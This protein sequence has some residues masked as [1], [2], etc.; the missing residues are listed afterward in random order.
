MRARSFID[1]YLHRASIDLLAIE[2][3]HR[4]FHIIF[5]VEAGHTAILHITPKT[6]P[7]TPFILTRFM[8]V[9]VRDIESCIAEHLF[10]V[11]QKRDVNS[12]SQLIIST[13]SIDSDV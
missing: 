4:A 9:C 3:I 12:T 6:M 1:V 10:Q 8:R 11:L 5:T 7:N 2:L 13:V